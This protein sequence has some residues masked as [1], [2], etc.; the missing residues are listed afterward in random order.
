MKVACERLLFINY[1]I[2]ILVQKIQ[3]LL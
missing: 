3:N 2:K 1:I